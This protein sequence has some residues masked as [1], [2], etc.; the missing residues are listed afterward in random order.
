MTD[1][2]AQMKKSSGKRGKGLQSPPKPEQAGH[3]IAQPASKP[4]AEAKPP[5]RSNRVSTYIS[6][7]AAETLDWLTTEI[8]RRDGRKPKVAEVLERGL[9]ALKSRYNVK[10]Q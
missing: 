7:D 3:N 8:R 10:T 4:A 1:V 9:D 5:A 2:F 6:D